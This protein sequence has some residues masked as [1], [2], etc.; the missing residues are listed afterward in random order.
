MESE[1]HDIFVRAHTPVRRRKSW[2]QRWSDKWPRYCLVFDT[3]TT[4]GTSQKLNFGCYR[5]CVLDDHGYRCIEEGLFYADHLPTK[6][7]EVLRKYKADKR[8]SPSIESF[9]AQMSLGL[10]T[11]SA[12]IS[13]VFWGAVR[14]G[15]LIVGFN[16]PFD[17]SMVAVRA[18]NGRR[19]SWSLAL[20]ARRSRRTGRVELDTDNQEFSLHLRTARWHS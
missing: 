16:L 9:P 3:E 13:R 14:R 11:R 1:R 8:N 5:R 17:L 19:S 10:M 18:G 2:K 6:D 7:L 20:S 12:F 4:V 15:E